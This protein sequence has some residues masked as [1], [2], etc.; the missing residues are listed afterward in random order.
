[1]QHNSPGQV[2]T[3][4][5]TR[6]EIYSCLE[7]YV[8]EVHGRINFTGAVRYNNTHG[9][10]LDLTEAILMHLY[11]YERY[12]RASS[13]AFSRASGYNLSLQPNMS[14]P[15]FSANIESL[16]VKDPYTKLRK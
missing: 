13:G 4:P 14:P 9:T 1:M 15:Y 6:D 10:T 12:L 8:D 5:L 2:L 16:K 3:S 11:K 7:A